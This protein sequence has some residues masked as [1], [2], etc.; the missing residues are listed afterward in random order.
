MDLTQKILDTINRYGMLRKGDKVL[1]A[2]SGG[3][4]SVCLTHILNRLKDKIGIELYLAHMD[5]GI[6][7]AESRRD[8]VFVKK[9]AESLGLKLACKKLNPKKIK[10]KLSLEERLRE[11]RYDFFKKARLALRA[12]CVATAHTLDDQAETVLMRIMKGASL[13][14]AVGIHPVRA[15]KDIKF[16]RPLIEIEKKDI[17]EYLKKRKVPFRIDRTNLENRF[18]RNK[19]RNSILPY[20]EKINPR[21]KRSLFNLAESLRE[22]YE[23]IEEEKKKRQSLIKSKKSSRYIGLPDILLQPKALQKEIVREALKS[24]GGNIKKL[25]FRHWKDIELFLRMKE[26]GK[27]LDLPGG[28][29][30][31]KAENRLIFTK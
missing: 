31:R 26:K 22:D 6:R 23:F 15:D 8:A 28:V 27:S 29:K 14:G 4:D 17:T 21:V 5:H 12:D 11:K 18:L 10:S 7:G 30:I 19:I 13:K 24:I 9:L 25:T 20:L 16:I 1:V 2:V 3:P